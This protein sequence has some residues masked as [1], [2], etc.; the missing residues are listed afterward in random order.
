MM[1][2]HKS[3]DNSITQVFTQPDLS[4][5]LIPKLKENII[6][7]ISDRMIFLKILK[8]QH[9]YSLIVPV[10]NESRIRLRVF[11]LFVSRY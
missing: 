3:S 10:G 2:I 7:H 11:L 5:E 9:N 8:Q 4:C 1:P 6:L